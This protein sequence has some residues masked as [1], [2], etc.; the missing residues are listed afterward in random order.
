VDA[1]RIGQAVRMGQ[2]AHAV[3]VGRL[4]AGSTCS[5]TPARGRGCQHGAGRSASNSGASRWQCVSIHMAAMMQQHAGAP[6]A[7]RGAT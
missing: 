6:P 7:A 2:R 1:Q 5:A 4:T 3:E